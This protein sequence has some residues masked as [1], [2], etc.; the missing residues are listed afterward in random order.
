M[1]IKG[2]KTFKKLSQSGIAVMS[3][4]CPLQVGMGWAE[5]A[6]TVDEEYCRRLQMMTNEGESMK[7]VA[8]RHCKELGIKYGEHHPGYGLRTVLMQDVDA[9]P[10]MAKFRD[11]KYACQRLG[12]NLY[13]K[14]APVG[15]SKHVRVRPRFEIWETTGV[16]KVTEE[17]IDDK[18][19]KQMCE[20]AGDQAGLSDW[21]PSSP[22]SPGPFG[23]FSVSLEQVDKP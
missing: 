10:P 11:Q 9:I 5:N 15:A 21:R 3:E 12:F 2:N 8:V 17:A 18:I 20:I 13:M 14:R 23:Q 4:F 7:D 22:K 1:I 16:F 19:L 6:P